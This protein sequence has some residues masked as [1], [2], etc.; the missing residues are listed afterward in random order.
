MNSALYPNW[1]EK[2]A[3]GE[4]GPQPTL[5]ASN[6]Q[7]KVVLAGLMPGQKIPAHP[8]AMATYHILEGS[9]W[10]TVD[11]T[12]YPVS[13]GATIITADGASRGI[14]ADTKLVFL[15]VRISNKIP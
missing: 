7:M 6:D 2:V 3:F 9:G 15:A 14:K 4:D 11:D 12:Q 8:E 10:M 5:L 1:Q 13:A